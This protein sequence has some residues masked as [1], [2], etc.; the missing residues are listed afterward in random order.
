MSQPKRTTFFEPPEIIRACEKAKADAV[1]SGDK[2]PLRKVFAV[3]ETARPGPNGTKYMDLVCTVGDKKDRLML[4]FREIHVGQ[5]APLDEAE[6]SRLNARRN[7]TKFGLLQKRDRHPTI[8]IQKWKCS[9]ETDDQGR[10][11]GNLPADDQKSEYY[12]VIEFIDEFFYEEMSARLADGRIC[13]Y[14]PR[15]EPPPG[16]IVIA[17]DKIVQMAQTHISRDSK[18]NPGAKLV[19]PITRLNMKFDKDTGM[20][21]A[22]FYDF[23]KSFNNPK[24]GKRD[25]EPLLFDGHPVTAHNV[26]NIQ[27][28]SKVSGI[29]NLNAVCSSNMGLSIPTDIEVL[30]VD[31]PLMREVDVSDVFDGDMFGDVAVSEASGGAVPAP[32]HDLDAHHSVNHSADGFAAS[33]AI[34]EDSMS[35][36]LNE[37]GVHH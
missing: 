31:P 2:H 37:L 10:L 27:S 20:P 24:T 13:K 30:V 6:V 22:K 28:H 1:A 15:K 3:G 12:R 16:A 21:K 5:I 14:D 8:N 19:N 4:R 23:T 36:V 34:S 18:T 9:I 35:E 33:A 7:S 17:N 26:H 32:L 11:K 29:A 25:F